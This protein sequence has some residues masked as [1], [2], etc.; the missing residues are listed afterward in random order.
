M[1]NMFQSSAL[2]IRARRIHKNYHNDIR[3]NGNPES[4]YSSVQPEHLGQIR[5]HLELASNF[6]T[7]MLLVVM[8]RYYCASRNGTMH[9]IEMW[10]DLHIGVRDPSE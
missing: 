7:R 8:Q 2:V 1:S 3:R 5:Q 6:E 9:L 4:L 10:G